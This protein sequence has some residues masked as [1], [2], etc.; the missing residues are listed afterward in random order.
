VQRKDCVREFE[1]GEFAVAIVV[2]YVE[3]HEI[4]VAIVVLCVG[5]HEP[6]A[7]SADSE[8]RASSWEEEVG[9]HGKAIHQERLPVARALGP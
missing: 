9:R 2:L 4:A 5:L 6:A 1:Q 3:L 7:G 8:N